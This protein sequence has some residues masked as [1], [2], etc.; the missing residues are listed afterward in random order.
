MKPPA[1]MVAYSID[2]A[3]FFFLND[4]GQNVNGVNRG[5]PVLL[6]DSPLSWI[7]F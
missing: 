5:F 1:Q 2:C 3:V 6:E 7:N 4:N